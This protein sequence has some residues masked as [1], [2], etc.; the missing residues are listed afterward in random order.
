V[1]GNIFWRKRNELRKVQMNTS[2][3][4]LGFLLLTKYYGVDDQKNVM[5]GECVM[6]G[7]EERCIQVYGGET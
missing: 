2:R 6:Y 1:L 3:G 5:D 4:V 7:R